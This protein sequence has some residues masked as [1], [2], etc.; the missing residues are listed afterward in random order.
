[1]ECSYSI[2]S[3][4]NFVSMTGNS[5]MFNGM[6]NVV[7]KITATIF[8]DNEE[9]KTS[10]Q[11]ICKNIKIPPFEIGTYHIIRPINICVERLSDNEY[12]ATFEE[13]DISF[14]ASTATEAIQELKIELIEV[15][16]LYKS[17]TCL[18]SWPRHQFDVL[19]GYIDK[20]KI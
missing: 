11:D 12:I 17:E 3:M 4:D 8:Q 19:E 13:A 14:S 20:K 7:E 18:G 16:E 9:E 1:M 5:K 10:S 2:A 6:M 15:Y